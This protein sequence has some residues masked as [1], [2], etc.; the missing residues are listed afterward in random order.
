VSA[1]LPS[2][3]GQPNIRLITCKLTL[4]VAEVYRVFG[5]ALVRF[6]AS[7]SIFY[8]RCLH[9]PQQYVNPFR[10]LNVFTA[11]YGMQ[12]RSN[13]ENPVSACLSVRPS[14]KRVDCDKGKNDMSR[15]LYHT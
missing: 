10:L 9:R 12:T 6:A 4:A 5:I 2:Y 7:V 1:L 8:I 15:F 14:V 3:Y 13:Y 11:L